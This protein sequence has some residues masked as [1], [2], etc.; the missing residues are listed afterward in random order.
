MTDSLLY[1]NHTDQPQWPQRR[2][3][4][5]RAAGMASFNAGLA[6]VSIIFL[7]YGVEMAFLTEFS[8]GRRK[9]GQ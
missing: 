6:A 7:T 4:L 8:T 9:I 1:L 5:H 3:L 2:A